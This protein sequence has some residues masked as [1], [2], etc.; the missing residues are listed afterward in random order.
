MK[1]KSILIGKSSLSLPHILVF[2]DEEGARIFGKMWP[3]LKALAVEAKPGY[4][5]LK[6]EISPCPGTRIPLIPGANLVSGLDVN[7]EGALKVP[8]LLDADFLEYLLLDLPRLLEEFRRGVLVEGLDERFTV[9]AGEGLSYAVSIMDRVGRVYAVPV[10]AMGGPS[11]AGLPFSRKILHVK[12]EGL[13]Y[14]DGEPL[15][16][17]V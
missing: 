1:V 14:L 7:L 5:P 9:H 16:R 11:L 15:C 6:V 2:T 10:V 12:G 17:V 13:I 4:S 8:P 3:H